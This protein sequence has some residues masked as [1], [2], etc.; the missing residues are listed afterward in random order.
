MLTQYH[1]PTSGYS[2]RSLRDDRP[3]RYFTSF[4]SALFAGHDTN[5]W[6]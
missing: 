4:A 2:S 3:F 5:M 6:M 1:L